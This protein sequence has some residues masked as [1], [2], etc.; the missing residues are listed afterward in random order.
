M[1]HEERGAQDVR[2]VLWRWG[3]IDRRINEL[4][5]QMRVAVDRANSLYELGGS[6]PMDGQPHGS[7]TG[8]P[9]YR[10][11]ERIQHM[12]EL[13]AAEIE[14]CEAQIKEAQEFK[15]AVNE[16]VSTLPP[17]QQ[18]ILRLRYCAGHNWVYIGFKVYMS[19]SNARRH[20]AL[21]CQKLS[22]LIEVRG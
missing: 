21:A 4:M 2:R 11:V 13:F 10:A 20:D 3:R 8:D 22:H 18:D 14:T 12:R 9:V 1:E 15:A 7:V 6:R 19:E 17:I 5:E 16:A